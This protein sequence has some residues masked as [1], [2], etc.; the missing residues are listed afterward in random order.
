MTGCP[1]TGPPPIP[2]LAHHLRKNSFAPP[3]VHLLADLLSSN[4]Q[5]FFQLV[6]S[7][8]ANSLFECFPFGTPPVFR[9]FDRGPPTY[10]PR[11]SEEG[12]RKSFMCNH[13]TSI[14]FPTILFHLGRSPVF[15]GPFFF[16]V[17]PS[18]R[19]T[20]PYTLSPPVPL[21]NFS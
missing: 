6:S 21:P 9:L 10:L 13:F 19:R 5:L 1:S 11:T 12:D 20:R 8:L 18:E 14:S 17:L 7:D 15:P 4:I 2:I 16:S 3:F